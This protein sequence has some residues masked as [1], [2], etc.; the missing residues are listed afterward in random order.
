MTALG[1]LTERVGIAGIHRLYYIRAQLRTH[2][3]GNL[4]RFERIVA[5]YRFAAGIHH[6][7]ERHSPLHALY[8]DA[9]EIGKHLRLARSAD[10]NMH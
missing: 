1:Y 9:T 8:G 5:V 6:R 3:C 7:K 10:V 2:T 4:N